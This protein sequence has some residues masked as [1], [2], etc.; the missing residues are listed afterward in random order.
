MEESEASIEAMQAS[1]PHSAGSRLLGRTTGRGFGGYDSLPVPSAT[2]TERQPFFPTMRTPRSPSHALGAA[3][4][5]PPALA[6]RAP[7]P[8]SSSIAHSATQVQITSPSAAFAADSIDPAMPY[9]RGGGKAA[10]IGHGSIALTADQLIATNDIKRRKIERLEKLLRGVITP[11]VLDE[12]GISYG[13]TAAHGLLAGGGGGGGASRSGA[14]R[15]NLLPPP[16]PSSPPSPDLRLRMSPSHRW[17]LSTSLQ[18]MRENRLQLLQMKENSGPPAPR[19]PPAPSAAAAATGTEV[20]GGSPPPPPP[21]QRQQQ[22]SSTASASAVLWSGPASLHLA[23]VARA[24][25]ARRVLR[26]RQGPVAEE[27]VAAD[28]AS[29]SATAAPVTAVAGSPVAAEADDLLASS[30]RRRRRQRASSMSTEAA[31][32]AVAAVAEAAQEPDSADVRGAVASLSLAAGATAAAAQPATAGGLVA[33][34]AEAAAEPE[35]PEA[36]EALP[37]D[38]SVAF[39]SHPHQSS[40]QHHHHHHHHHNRQQQQQL[41]PQEAPEGEGPEA[42]LVAVQVAEGDVRQ[43]SQPLLLPLQEEQQQQQQEVVE[44]RE[45]CRALGDV[46]NWVAGEIEGDVQPP[47]P[48]PPAPPHPAGENVATRSRAAVVVL[49][50][51]PARAA[52]AITGG[53]GGIDSAPSV[54]PRK[55]LTSRG[56]EVEVESC[57]RDDGPSVRSLCLFLNSATKVGSLELNAEQMMWLEEKLCAQ[58]PLLNCVD[59]SN[60]MSSLARLTADPHHYYDYDYINNINK[61]NDNNDNNINNINNDKDHH[62]FNQQSHHHHHHHQQQ[63]QQGAVT[64]SSHYISHHH[65]YYHHRQQQQEQQ[66]YYDHHNRRNHNHQQDGKG[67][68]ESSG[69]AAT[70][71]ATAVRSAVAAVAEAM[72]SVGG[73]SSATTN[74]ISRR[75]PITTTTT[76]NDEVVHGRKIRVRPRVETILAILWRSAQLLPHTRADEVVTLLYSLARLGFRAPG[77]YTTALLSR[78]LS[79][80]HAC[81][82]QA[83]ALVIWAAPR[84]RRRPPRSWLAAMVEQAV[85]RVGDFTPPLLTALLC[86]LARACVS[87]GGRSAAAWSA[88]EPAA[89][90][91]FVR[92]VAELLPSYDAPRDLANV[93][94][95]LAT[96]P[97]DCVPTHGSR[98]WGDLARRG[99]E[100]GFCSFGSQSLANLLWSLA[101]V[102]VKR[103][104][105]G[106]GAAVVQ[107][108]LFGGAAGVRELVLALERNL[109]DMNAAELSMTLWAL[110]QLRLD[111][112]KHWVEAAAQRAVG[113]LRRMR[114]RGLSALVHS[115]TWIKSYGPSE[116]VAELQRRIDKEPVRNHLDL[117]HRLDKDG[118]RYGKVIAYRSSELRAV[119]LLDGLCSSMRDYSLVHPIGK[120]TKFWLK[121]KG[122]GAGNTGAVTRPQREEEDEKS[123][124]KVQNGKIVPHGTR[125]PGCLS[126]P[127][128][129]LEAYCGTLLE[130]Y[131]EEIYAGVMKGGFDSQ[132]VEAV[133]CRSIISPCPIAAPAPSGDTESAS[134]AAAA[135]DV[136]REATAEE[137]AAAASG[138]VEELT[139]KGDADG[140]VEL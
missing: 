24:R 35:M 90:A 27:P 88:L 52:T 67:E 26:R 113:L 49:K 125:Q 15:R 135:D 4:D 9:I 101:K 85:R 122:E 44:G 129:R 100:L 111:P 130:E 77:E 86:G 140:N 12:Y 64:R 98:F 132:G 8:R 139:L 66:Y 121:V 136:E 59:V 25:T 112:G 11:S 93:A 82:P 2:S 131:E 48:P 72:N 53:D 23:V 22:H 41:L 83:L 7:I 73:Y 20:H 19:D 50:P 106:G 28:V 127:F 123:K 87:P 14:S 54:A 47:P 3:A 10:S 34:A 74:N 91:P 51:R 17:L 116:E 42:S 70:A 92:R 138:Y 33:E 124:G 109:Y 65:H 63:Q 6:T 89:A 75:V 62:N 94:W 31:A 5:I 78:C 43:P 133:L 38:R 18:K 105:G 1:A 60:V 46:A 95:A 126:P 107:Y 37:L 119:E 79:L 57:H 134:Q 114:L 21:P 58:A 40:H 128:V 61:N 118:Q 36:A 110:G 45:P 39:P 117:R 81:T 13:S 76:N 104:G 137:A 32:T 120:K 115:I 55:P 99:R 30:R 69:I 68:M 97:P 102:A 16:L 71:T 96:L 84:I 108:Q 29:T 56:M 103:S 80:R